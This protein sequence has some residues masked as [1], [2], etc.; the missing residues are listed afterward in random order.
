MLSIT[1]KYVKL[2]HSTKERG[3]LYGRPP[4]SLLSIF[5]EKRKKVLKMDKKDMSDRSDKNHKEACE[6]EMT[7]QKSLII[8]MRDYIFLPIVLAFVLLLINQV[9][10]LGLKENMTII[11]YL[12]KDFLI[13]WLIATIGF[14]VG[15]NKKSLL[16][17]FATSLSVTIYLSGINSYLT[18]L[19]GFAGFFS[20]LGYC[21][22][23][24]NV[25][26]VARAFLILV[27]FTIGIIG[28]TFKYAH[29][30]NDV[31]NTTKSL[32]VEQFGENEYLDFK[33]TFD[34]A[35]DEK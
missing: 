18:F 2:K 9:T 13:L 4:L 23:K 10:S 6:E 8:Q 1:F 22:R 24:F 12:T 16:I 14:S 29:I 28:M 30:L 20:L 25:K 27:G 3:L 21:E 32:I 31:N 34:K 35:M 5:W 7:K 17:L 26:L 11:S 33:K 15:L 19:H